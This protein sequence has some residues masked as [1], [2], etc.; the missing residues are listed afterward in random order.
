MQSDPSRQTSSIRPFTI[1]VACDFEPASGYAFDL[2]VQMDLRIP[3]SHLDVIHIVG[4][5][6]D[7]ANMS[8]RA[9]CAYT[10][11]K[12]PPPTLTLGSPR[13]FTCAA[14]TSC[15]SLPSS[16]PTSRPTCSC[17]GLVLTGISTTC[18]APPPSRR[19]SR[20]W[21]PAPF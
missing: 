16:L 1:V 3:G 15:A 19:G 9:F 2:A 7:A 13:E 8:W 17:S 18:C 5:D 10:S 11:K 12:R 4:D 14:A 6:T 20:G 21:Y